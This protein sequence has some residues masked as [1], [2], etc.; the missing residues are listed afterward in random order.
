MIYVEVS[1]GREVANLLRQLPGQYQARGLRILLNNAAKPLVDQA[2]SNAP[3]SGHPHW[4]RGNKIPSG[5]LKKSIGI[6]S[7]NRART[8]TIAV[9]PRAKGA[10]GGYKGGWYAWFVERG[11]MVGKAQARSGGRRIYREGTK[12][13]QPNPFMQSAWD[14]QNDNARERFFRDATKVFERYVNRMKARGKL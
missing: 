14:S 6:I 4:A 11:H 1:N 7:L 10:F 13:V 2:R 9:G 3:V 12:K 8:V 5:T